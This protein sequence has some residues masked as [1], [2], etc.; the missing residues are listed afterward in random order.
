MHDPLRPMSTKLTRRDFLK[1]G[2][3]VCLAPLARALPAE[4]EEARTQEQARPN[5][6][7]LIF[8][9]MSAEHLSLYG[10]PRK[11]SPNIERLA[12]RATVYHNHHSAANFTTPSTASLFSGTYP[13]THRAFTLSGLVRPQV[14]SNNLLQVLD[15][16]YYQAGF[17]QNTYADLLL[18]QFNERMPRHLGPD[19]FSAAGNTI[20]DKLFPNDAINGLMS[21]DQF[22]FKPESRRGS[23][24]LSIL[25]DVRTQMARRLVDARMSDLHPDGLPDLSSVE[26]YFAIEEVMSGVQELLSSL[27]APFFSY[28]HLMPPH[29][30][31]LPARD[32][33]GMFSDGWTPKR[34]K[35]HPLATRL[36]E[37]RLNERR[38]NYDEYIANLD[39]E[40]GKLI[41]HLEVSGVLEDSYLIVTS[42]HGELFE[43]GEHGHVNPF[44]FEPV[45]RVPLLI[46]APGQRERRDFHALTS[47][48]DLL[49]TLAQITGVEQP[50]WCEGQLL[51][52]FGGEENTDRS[53]FSLEAKKNPAHEPLTKATIC[54][55]RGRYKLIRYLG[56]RTYDEDEFFDL[57]NDPEERENL[58]DAHP[59]VQDLQAEL[60]DKLEQVNRPYLENR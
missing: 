51:P 38:Q 3:A 33:R 42:D 52:G 30:P 18:Y 16:A 1:L 48:V 55:M 24:F 40:F 35:R 25:N 11:T 36:S 58:I 39:F 8:D 57:E 21:Y 31:Y 41:D 19:S 7:V 32:F 50:E 14:R 49:P 45:I 12:G 28:V 26:I 22:L 27:P 44:L 5:V 15:S 59:A 17:A 34:K 47:N 43:R 4:L 2:S 6:I 37:E 54:L 13:W 29:T 46:A 9:A 53:V 10:Y 56:Y 20:F 23:L 60:D